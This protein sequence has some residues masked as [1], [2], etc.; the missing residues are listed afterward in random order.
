[1]NI[2]PTRSA[3]ISREISQER[4]KLGEV[5][6]TLAKERFWERLYE[7]Q[8][9]ALK[10]IKDNVSHV[11]DSGDQGIAASAESHVDEGGPKGDEVGKSKEEG[12]VEEGGNETD[13]AGNEAEEGTGSADAERDDG[14]SEVQ[15]PL[16]PSPT[17]AEPS[18]EAQEPQSTQTTAADLRVPPPF[19]TS[20]ENLDTSNHPEL[21]GSTA[22]HLV[23]GPDATTTPSQTRGS[24]PDIP[25][26]LS[27]H[28]IPTTTRP[29][30]T[31]AAVVRD[32]FG[33]HTS[34][35]TS[36]TATLG[37]STTSLTSTVNS[38]ATERPPRR[39]SVKELES[40][41]TELK[42]EHALAK[43][44]LRNK[45]ALN[46]DRRRSIVA[47]GEECQQLVAGLTSKDSGARNID[48]IS[49]QESETVEAVSDLAVEDPTRNH[50]ML[51]Q[52]DILN[53]GNE[54]GAL[55]FKGDVLGH[56]QS[57]DPKMMSLEDIKAGNSPA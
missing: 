51:V 6:N 25:P 14:S 34:D 10:I 44:E 52:E 12:E 53:S 43:Q 4:N 45:E 24:V 36:P 30:A 13:A 38:K 9:E 16:T 22:A 15:L 2:L 35:T 39:L 20:L 1:M 19:A 11:K 28:M 40:E 49:P 56:W 33:R 31:R 3:R 8:I 50:T 29:G 54:F 37:T 42:R 7:E 46:R 5:R 48:E 17:P 41:L 26:I 47:I 23:R 18:E 55:Q 21:I 32:F 57:D 27:A